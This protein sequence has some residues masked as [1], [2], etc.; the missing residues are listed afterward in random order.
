MSAELILAVIATADLCLK[1]VRRLT[2]AGY[3]VLTEVKIWE[4]A[5]RTVPGD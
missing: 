1:Y 3:M 5:Y 2:L 4:R